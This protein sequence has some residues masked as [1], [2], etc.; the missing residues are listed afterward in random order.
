M[1]FSLSILIARFLFQSYVWEIL[2][3]VSTDDPTF[4]R[5]NEV[6]IFRDEKWSSIGIFT[7][8]DPCIPLD[9]VV[10]KHYLAL[11]IETGP[12]TLNFTL[13]PILPLQGYHWECM[14][15]TMHSHH[16]KGTHSEWNGWMAS[17]TQWTWVWEIVKD[18]EAWCAAGH[19]D[20]DVTDQLNTATKQKRSKDLGIQKDL[21]S[22]YSSIFLR[23]DSRGPVMSQNPYL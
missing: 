12:K 13:G 16:I 6:S 22:N 3:V 8:F 11:I 15:P 7:W 19:K 2:S 10:N 21:D 1:T 20:S 5:L 9:V 14:C 18:R 4:I 17:S 23:F